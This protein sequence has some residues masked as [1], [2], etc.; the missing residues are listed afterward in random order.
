MVFYTNDLIDTPSKDFLHSSIETDSEEAIFCVGGLEYVER[1]DDECRSIRKLFHCPV[2]IALYNLFMNGVDCVDQRIETMVCSRRENK[3]STLLYTHVLDLSLSNA[4]A[5]Y[6]FCME[7]TKFIGPK[8]SY[9]DFRM[10]VAKSLT[11]DSYDKRE[12][13]STRT[14]SNQLISKDENLNHCFLP[15]LEGKKIKCYFCFEFVTG[16]KKRRTTYGCQACKV[17]FCQKLN[18]YSFFH[19]NPNFDEIKTKLVETKKNKINPCRTLKD[20]MKFC[21]PT[22]KDENFEAMF[23]ESGN[24]IKSVVKENEKTRNNRYT[25]NA[26]IAHGTK[27]KNKEKKSS[28]VV[29]E[30]YDITIKNI[31]ESLEEWADYART[32][33]NDSDED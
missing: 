16:G 26:R 1:W 9:S 13:T 18:C 19:E 27:K 28:Q 25:L 15:V 6:L 8:Y 3:M 7:S 11:Q 30:D 12:N 24:L 21:H 2:F 23:E 20:S 22:M 4:Y 33:N 29:I 31:D 10:S 32:R 5:L 17:G 14:I